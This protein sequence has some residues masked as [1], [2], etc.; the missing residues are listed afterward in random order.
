MKNKEEINMAYLQNGCHSSDVIWVIQNHF[1][2][3]ETVHMHAIERL[4][5]DGFH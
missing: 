5:P 1:D 4:L 2:K 3:H